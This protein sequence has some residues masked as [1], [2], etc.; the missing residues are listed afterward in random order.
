MI[1]RQTTNSTVSKSKN[2][3]ED[4]KKKLVLKAEMALMHMDLS[5]CI[6]FR[7]N[8]FNKS[9]LDALKLF[10]AKVSEMKRARE[11][12]KNPRIDKCLSNNL[13]EDTIN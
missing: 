2:R 4:S 12:D 7:K 8:E 9:M 3:K 11:N 1:N 6:E 10:L 5:P 13:K